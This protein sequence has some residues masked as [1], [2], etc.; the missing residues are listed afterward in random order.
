MKPK[1]MYNLYYLN[2]Y[3]EDDEPETPFIYNKIWKKTHFLIRCQV[4]HRGLC[5]GTAVTKTPRGDNMIFIEP[6]PTCLEAARKGE[7]PEPYEMNG[8]YQTRERF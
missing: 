7:E 8:E 5:H 1:D 6:C 4:C 2:G 3:N